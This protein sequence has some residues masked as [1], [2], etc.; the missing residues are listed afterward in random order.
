MVTRLVGISSLS[1]TPSSPFKTKLQ[2]LLVPWR[3]ELLMPT[4][5]AKATSAG[6]ETHWFC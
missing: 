4:S 5:A 6:L 1:G 3:E 2:I